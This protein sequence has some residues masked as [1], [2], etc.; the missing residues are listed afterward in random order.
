MSSQLIF[1]HYHY[2]FETNSFYCF[3]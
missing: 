3:K 1:V 2:R